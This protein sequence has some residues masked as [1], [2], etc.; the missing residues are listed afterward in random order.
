MVFGKDLNDPT[1]PAFPNL[2]RS[3]VVPFNPLLP[4]AAFPS[5]PLPRESNVRGDGETSVKQVANI[6]A[7]S[8]GQL[9]MPVYAYIKAIEILTTV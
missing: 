4:P 9:D 6:K 5:L 7:Q 2:L 8:V 3:Q 1:K